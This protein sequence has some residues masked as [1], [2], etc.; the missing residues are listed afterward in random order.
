MVLHDLLQ[1]ALGTA[2]V[3][4]HI[5]V[6]GSHDAHAHAHHSTGDRLVDLQGQV[7][8]AE[9]RLQQH[10]HDDVAT[11]GKIDELRAQIR[12]EED[13]RGPMIGATRTIQD[14]M[15]QHDASTAS[16]QAAKAVDTLG[17]YHAQLGNYVANFT[18]QRHNLQALYI[19]L[20][21]QEAGARA[22]GVAHPLDGAAEAAGLDASV[23]DR[24]LCETHAFWHRI[25]AATTAAAVKPVWA[26]HCLFG[27]KAVPEHGLVPPTT[28]IEAACP[29]TVEYA[30]A[31][32][33]LFGVPSPVGGCDGVGSPIRWQE[34]L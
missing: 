22:P 12:D 14:T 25:E 31:A 33:F 2:F 19:R 11:R 9:Q 28:G 4:A 3:D 6:N 13:Y 10:A 20:D 24:E 1:H 34:F 29:V 17:E 15:Q 8:R 16:E 7:H 32:A 27:D 30:S 23:L 26:Q 18:E 21:A 5:V